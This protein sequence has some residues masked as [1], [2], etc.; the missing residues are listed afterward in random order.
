M[1][2]SL[3]ARRVP[4]VPRLV[5]A[6]ALLF[7]LALT[8]VTPH[9]SLAQNPTETDASVRFVHA[10]PD[11]PAVDVVVDGA[12]V[13]SDLAFGQATDALSLSPDEHQ[14]QIVPT[15]ED[16]SSAV[17]DTKLDPDGSTTYIVAVSGLLKDIEAKVYDVHKDDLDAGKSRLRLINLSPEDT[18]VDFYV[19]GGDK[20]FDDLAFG[21]ASD[22]TDLDTGS[23]DFEVRPHDQETAALSIPA[24]EVQDGNAYDL[25]LIGTAADHTLSVVP[26][27]TPVATP[28]SAVLNIGTPDDAC[29]RVIH[30]SPDAPAVDIYVN[31]SKVIENL[32][33][34]A[35]T[36][37]AAL[38][39]GNDR[40][41]Q[42]VS[43]GST[44]DDAIFDTKVDLGPGKAYDVVAVGMADD[45]D[46]VVEN[47]DLSA[48]PEG[49]ARVR[50]IHAAPDVD[51]VDVVVTDG[52]DLFTGVDFKDTTDYQTI[53]AGTYDLQVKNGDDV[54]IRVQDFTI[55]AGN[56]Y[57]VL[58]IGR[59]DDGSLQLVAFS[60][61]AE[62]PTGTA[63]TPALASTPMTVEE[64]TPAIEAT[65]TS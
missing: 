5:V 38:P 2:E 32:A 6:L 42:I 41:I 21:K 31:G 46:A 35:G 43:T 65:P 36:D 34:G 18:N 60:A 54:L 24:F 25:L 9:L 62:S 33:Y 57:D 64:A 39:S 40:E 20:L 48:V 30:A 45:L 28:C 1:F 22:Y 37:F 8:A 19:T 63:A 56:V 49:Q 47:V 11:A 59:S 53:D 51:G 4:A 26:L 50:M 52:P 44:V 3:P 12:V 15:G 58:V 23:Y 61:P 29:V 27:T 14:L 55:E 17:V 7:S 16:A 13:A 10:S